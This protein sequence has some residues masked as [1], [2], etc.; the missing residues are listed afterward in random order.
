MAAVIAFPHSTFSGTACLPLVSGHLQPPV[1]ERPLHAAENALTHAVA[2]GGLPH[3]RR[4]A[5][6]EEDR[7]FRLEKRLE[8]GHDAP[9]EFLEVVAAMAD[10]RLASAARFSARTSVGQG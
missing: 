2:Y 10:L 4:R 7:V 8:L 1:G 6:E 5:R 3:A 9:V